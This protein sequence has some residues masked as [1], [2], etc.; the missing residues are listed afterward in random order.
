MGATSSVDA[1]AMEGDSMGA[2]G[3]GA[4]YSGS[5]AGASTDDSMRPMKDDVREDIIFA[6]LRNFL[7][8]IR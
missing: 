5:R 2:Q 3:S 8:P 6:L 4:S 1:H 7:I